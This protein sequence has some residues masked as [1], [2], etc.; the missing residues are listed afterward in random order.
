MA[1]KHVM[2]DGTCLDDI[3]GHIIKMDEA[4]EFYM[5]LEGIIKGEC[6]DSKFGKENKCNS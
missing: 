6:Y 1:V 4:R 3:S 5:I 2:K